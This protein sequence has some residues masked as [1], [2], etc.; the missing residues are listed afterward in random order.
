MLNDDLFPS[1]SECQPRRQ[2]EEV[3]FKRNH[4]QKRKK[5]PETLQN[6]IS[7]KDVHRGALSGMNV[8]DGSLGGAVQFLAGY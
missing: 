7:E 6:N 4:L 2:Q 5:R 1:Q 3:G 8:M